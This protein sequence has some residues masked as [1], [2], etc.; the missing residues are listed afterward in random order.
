M[1]APQRD[2]YAACVRLEHAAHLVGRLAL[3]L[4]TFRGN[5]VLRD[6]QLIAAKI[7]VHRGEEHASGVE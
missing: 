6:P 1:S 2:E 5:T 4:G 3:G 7:G